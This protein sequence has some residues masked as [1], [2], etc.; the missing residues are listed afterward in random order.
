MNGLFGGHKSAVV[1]FAWAKSFIVSG[2]REGGLAFWDINRNEPV[3]MM[4]GHAQA[5]GKICLYS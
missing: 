2:D 1:D 4:K 3:R 5:V